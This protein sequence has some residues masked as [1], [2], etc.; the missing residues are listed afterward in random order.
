MSKCGT[1]REEIRGFEVMSVPA[2]FRII[3]PFENPVSVM[4]AS[5]SSVDRQAHKAAPQLATPQYRALNE[6]PLKSESGSQVQC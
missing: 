3:I 4:V 5:G 1:H 2:A 6:V